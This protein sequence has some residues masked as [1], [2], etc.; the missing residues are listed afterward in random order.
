MTKS[1]G[2]GKAAGG[3]KSTPKPPVLKPSKSTGGK[4][5]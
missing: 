5:K 2:G 1:Y 4:G 3:G